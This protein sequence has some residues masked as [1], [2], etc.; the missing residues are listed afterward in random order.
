MKELNHARRYID[1]ISNLPSTL[2]I[3]PVISSSPWNDRTSSSQQ[4]QY[5]HHQHL[6]HHR[7]KYLLS[8]SKHY[9][10]GLL[11]Q[12]QEHLT[13][14]LEHYNAVLS[15]CRRELGH[16]HIYVATVQEKKGKVL[17][18]QRKLQTATLSYLASLSVYEKQFGNGNG[19][20]NGTGYGGGTGRTDAVSHSSTQGRQGRDGNDGTSQRRR[21]GRRHGRRRH[22]PER[23][24]DWEGK[25][26]E[27][28]LERSRILYEIGRTLH[29]REEY[30]DALRV[31]KKALSMKLR[32]SQELDDIGAAAADS[33]AATKDAI[34][35]LTNIGR[36][37]HIMGDLDEALN[38][39]VKIANMALAV[40]GG[41]GQR[42]RQNEVSANSRLDDDDD[43]DDDNNDAA[44]QHDFVR[45]QF[46]VLGNLYVEVGRLDEAMNIFS[47]IS[48]QQQRQQQRRRRQLADDSG[49]G[50]LLQ[51][52]ARPEEEDV[53]TTSA[54][55]VRAAERLGNVG[56]N[57]THPYSAAA[58]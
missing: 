58:A 4:Q 1:T 55:A 32:H 22:Q 10:D 39:N 21:H 15:L 17:F 27:Y 47:R 24:R 8:L 29:D 37:H 36:M 14:A 6:L 44:L 41:G 45:N 57:G 43:D 48:R 35:I 33:T 50:D 30:F 54:F 31:Y 46:V 25:E 20:G 9:H 26:E 38:A 19:N 49:S 7:Y 40:V 16:N 53:D 23:H 5:Q 3:P 18:D 51:N 34:R 11:Q 56:G 13:P 42:R 12:R 2:V 52:H 28:L